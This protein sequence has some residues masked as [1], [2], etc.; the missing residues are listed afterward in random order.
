MFSWIPSTENQNQPK[1]KQPPPPPPGSSRIYSSACEHLL[2]SSVVV[3]A[4]ESDGAYSYILKKQ[5][6]KQN[7]TS[8]LLPHRQTRSPLPS[9]PLHRTW[10]AQ[11]IPGMWS[12]LSF[13]VAPRRARD[14]GACPEADQTWAHSV[15]RGDLVASLVSKSVISFL[16]KVAL[17]QRFKNSSKKCS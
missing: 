2:S 10:I 7:P 5:K 16:K 6:Q 11:Q 1:G 3:L 15:L 14:R 12:P 8:L 13:P 4:S 9:A 17:L